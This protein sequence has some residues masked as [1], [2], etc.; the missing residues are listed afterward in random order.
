MSKMIR[1][2]RKFEETVKLPC[3]NLPVGFNI[4]HVISSIIDI[5]SLY[6]QNSAP[7]NHGKHQQFVKWIM[8]AE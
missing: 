7:A 1:K 4:T 5:R 6:V 3:M 8:E 2:I